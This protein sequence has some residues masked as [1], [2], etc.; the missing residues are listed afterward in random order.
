M[1]DS[2]KFLQAPVRIT[3]NGLAS[4]FTVKSTDIFAVYVTIRHVHRSEYTVKKSVD[5]YG[6]IPGI[7]LP[8]LLPLFLRAFTCRTFLEIKI[9]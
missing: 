5:F 8:V 1:P 3:G 7:W 2:C 6:K 4:D 9:W